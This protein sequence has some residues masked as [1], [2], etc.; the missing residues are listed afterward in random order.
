M[1]EV[2]EKYGKK[3]QIDVILNSPWKDYGDILDEPIKNT[4][5]IK[6]FK[7]GIKSLFTMPI[8]LK[9]ETKNNK[10]KKISEGFLVLKLDIT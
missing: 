6:I 3:K 5:Y 7:K 2:V 4:N 9:I 1:P 8:E 10:F